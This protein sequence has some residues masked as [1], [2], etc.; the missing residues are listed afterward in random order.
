[1]K[2]KTKVV[3]RTLGAA[4]LGAV[5]YAIL[6]FFFDRIRGEN[7]GLLRYSIQGLVFFVAMSIFFFLYRKK[8]NKKANKD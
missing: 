7:I 4:F 1:M 2:M 6:S 8:K 3:L 5:G